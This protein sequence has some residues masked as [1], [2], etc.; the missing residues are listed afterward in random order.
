LIK[1]KIHTNQ[2]TG[3]S[4]VEMF[5]EDELL[6]FIKDQTVKLLQ[7]VRKH[8]IEIEDKDQHIFEL[9]NQAHQ[10]KQ[11]R[12]LNDYSKKEVDYIVIL[13]Q[14]LHNEKEYFKE[15]KQYFKPELQKSTISNPSK[16]EDIF[17]EKDYSKYIQLLKNAKP[18]LVTDKLEYIG[19]KRNGKGI[20][21]SWLKE[22]QLTGKVY[23][24]YNRRQ[25]AVV[26]NNEIKE[27]NIGLD[28]KTLDNRSK[29]FENVYEEQLFPNN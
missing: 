14:W 28:G 21:G 9:L 5:S 13:E 20:I 2:F 11:D 8:P 15:A 7:L 6:S 12:L 19:S 23:I 27:L 18:K 16:F 3:I 22:L 25:L 1:G 24:G 10:I 29:T 26:L 4:E 17:I